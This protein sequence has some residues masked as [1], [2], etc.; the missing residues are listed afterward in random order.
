MSGL[1]PRQIVVL[2]FALA[3]GLT[4]SVVALSA[5]GGDSE[6]LFEQRNPPPLRPADVERVVRTAPDP[7]VGSG[8]GRSATCT[9]RGSGPLKNPWACVVTYDSGRKARLT[10]RITSDGSY[11]GRYAGGG[12]AR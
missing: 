6:F 12:Q 11:V 3:T 5:A 7:A 9:P 10:V 4:G 1:R 8:E 2:A